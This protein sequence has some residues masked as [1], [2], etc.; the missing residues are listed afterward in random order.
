MDDVVRQH[1]KV[2]PSSLSRTVKCP[3]SLKLNEG[4]N[5]ESKYTVEGTKA[6]MVA[7]YFVREAFGLGNDHDFRE[8]EGKTG[9]MID[10]AEK[11]VQF[12]RNIVKYMH[13][14]TDDPIQ[15]EVEKEVHLEEY[16]DEC[17]GTC[18]LM[19]IGSDRLSIC[20]YK[21]G[22]GKVEVKDNSQLKAYALGAYLSIDP[23]KRV[24]IRTI[25]TY[26]FQPRASFYNEETR[27]W[28]TGYYGRD[29]FTPEQL[30]DWAFA[31]EKEVK[32]ALDGEGERSGGDHCR[33]CTA[34]GTCEACLGAYKPNVH[35][36]VIESN[37][38]PDGDDLPDG[39][40]DPFS[41][42]GGH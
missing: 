25:D 24:G 28:E 33:F 20:D 23:E 5:S 21:Y 37:D 1:A 2:S 32:K 6:H 39:G 36:R 27:K 30:I 13:R 11:Y 38:L 7:E 26:I 18:D 10:C 22:G 3:P 12:A 19:F 31:A 4:V 16:I 41:G 40:A 9:Q 14:T 29:T 8:I 17:W 35:K 34:K 15:V 42:M